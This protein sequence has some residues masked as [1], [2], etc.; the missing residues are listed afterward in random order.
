MAVDLPGRL[1]LRFGHFEGRSVALD[2]SAEAGLAAFVAGSTDLVNL[3]QQG[4]AVAVER[5]V[6]DGLGVA[7]GFAFHP[8]LLPR[9]APEVGL[10]GVNGL[11]ERRAVH[12]RHHQ[13]P[14]S[15]LFLN[16][17]RDQ[18]IGIKLQFIVKSHSRESTL[19]SG[20]YS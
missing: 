18:A 7:A 10:A 12:P 2:G 6:F 16:D 8:E 14:A 11:F 3:D 5:D 9:P 20:A 1:D 15:L 17:S 19:T 13:H 4:V